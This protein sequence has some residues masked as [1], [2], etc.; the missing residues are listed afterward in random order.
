MRTMPRLVVYNS[1]MDRT[2]EVVEL[3]R[4]G[5][6]QREVG[7]SV[8]VSATTVGRIL[9]AAGEP[10]R[11]SNW[12]AKR[13]AAERFWEKVSKDPHPKGCWLWTAH[14]N[15]GGYGAFMVDTNGKRRPRGAHR[16]AYELARGPIPAGLQLDH[17]CRVRNCVNPDH[18]EAVTPL[19]NV[20]RGNA[21]IGSGSRQLAKTSCPHGHPYDEANTGYNTSGGR[22]CRRCARER[23]RARRA[24]KRAQP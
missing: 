23:A 13:P 8:G 5:L 2:R 4:S 19:E 22:I 18:L 16:F 15:W 12:K 10:A 24:A 11:R 17:L 7:A 1:L 9:A 14:V 3:Y 21:G 6:S 20:R